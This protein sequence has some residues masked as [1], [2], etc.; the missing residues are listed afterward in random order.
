MKKIFTDQLGTTIEINFPPMRIISL[1]PSLTELLVELGLKNNIVGITN[2]CI[3]PEELQNEIAIV[4]GTK[5]FDVSK[6]QMLSPDLIIA[7]KEEN[8][9]EGIELLQRDF[10]VWVSDIKDLY[11]ALHAMQ[12]IGEMTDKVKEAYKI[13]YTIKKSFDK[14]VPVKKQKVIYLIW[15]KPYMS[16]GG[17]TF[18]HDMLD[19]CGFVNLYQDRI[20]YPQL[21]IDDL[22][23]ANP[24]IVLLSTEPYPFK[25]KHKDEMHQIL[26]EAKI[27]LADGE[28][29]SWYGSRLLGSVD[30]FKQLIN[31]IN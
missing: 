10:P 7:S 20:R 2:Y 18:I 27:V 25:E 3:H 30:Y 1:V 19:R 28:Y 11:E 31:G 17:D 14:L 23:A 5:N 29:F 9:K 12:I 15:R 24:D 22:K 6:I 8:T 16:V 26:P 13:A 21:T 4:G